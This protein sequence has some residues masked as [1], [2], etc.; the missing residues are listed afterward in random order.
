[1]KPQICLGTAQFGL[2]YGITNNGGKVPP[3]EVSALLSQAAS[4]GIK[5]I[6]TAQSY[7]DAEE[8]LGRGFSAG[9]DFRLITKLPAQSQDSFGRDSVANWEEAFHVSCRRLG[10]DQLDGFL[11]H[12][13]D[14]LRKPGSDYLQKWLISLRDRGLVR[15]L[16]VSIYAKED[17]ANVDSNLLDLVQLPLSIYDQ[18]LL[19][20]G[21][22][23][24]LQKLGC[25][26][27]IRSVYLQGL[28]ISPTEA[29]PAWI[30]DQARQ[31]H[32]NFE[33]F[34]LGRSCSLLELALSFVRALEGLEAVVIGLC[35]R[36]E[37]NELV[38]AWEGPLCLAEGEGHSW[39]SPD[40]SIL[41]P[42]YWPR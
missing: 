33:Q 14:D 23:G 4:S 32:S 34:S 28:L 2:S 1:M 11:L 40:I 10:V 39:A 37:L 41:D 35:S 21:T 17:L 9:Q 22:I 3:D 30:S 29:W 13:P 20:D 19:V 15:R 8:V 27:H 24:L 6:D 12:S 38:Q 26:I 31:H 36:L 42:R 7:G 18:R 16:G 5:L 25:A